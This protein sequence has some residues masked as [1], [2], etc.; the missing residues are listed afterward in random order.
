MPGFHNRKPSR[1]AQRYKSWGIDQPIKRCSAASTDQEAVIERFSTIICLPFR[2]MTVAILG[3]Y[4]QSPIR[5]QA[6]ERCCE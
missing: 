6:V 2:E 3:G 1:A 5:F 4:E